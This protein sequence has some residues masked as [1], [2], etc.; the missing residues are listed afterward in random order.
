MA[1]ERFSKKETTIALGLAV[2]YLSWM[3]L[4]VGLRDDHV[5]LLSF[6]LIMFFATETT[7]KLALSLVFFL[8]YWILYDS[9]RIYPNYEFNPV[10]IRE[11]YDIDKWLFGFDYLGEKVTPNEFF[12][13]NT[14]PVLDVLTGLFYLCWIPVPLGFAVWLFFKDKRML[15]DFALC[16]L[17]V[18]IFG[19]MLYYAYPAAPP[20]YVEA[21]GFEKNFNILG[22]EA[23]LA[24]FDHI[25]GLTIFRDMYVKNANVFAAIPSLHSAFPV[26]PLYFALKRKM[27]L[28]SIA[29]LIVCLGIW[30]TAVYSRHHYIID[31]LAGILCALATI[32]VFERLVLKTR[33]NGWL[34]RYT[35]LIK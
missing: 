13:E 16:F 32:L 11:P 29:F 27:K 34:N 18:N 23:G 12:E 19:I 26:I 22:S 8:I 9:M 2:V 4:V 24:N 25:M 5:F 17:L 35:E 10:H 6:C 30:F 7:R 28:A 1:F 31:V 14:T 20:W 21:H 3:T 33:V 15:L